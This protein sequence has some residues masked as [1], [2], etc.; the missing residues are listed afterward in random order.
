MKERDAYFSQPPEAEAQE[1]VPQLPGYRGAE[2]EH[3]RRQQ[4]HQKIESVT[5]VAKSEVC[6]GGGGGEGGGGGG[7]EGEWRHAF[8]F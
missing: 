5:N 6:V 7:G 8:H 2:I 1:S 4:K 3:S